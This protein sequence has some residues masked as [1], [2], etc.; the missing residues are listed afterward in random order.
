MRSLIIY[1]SLYGNTEKI[2]KAIGDGISGEVKVL[3]ANGVD[4]A[5]LKGLN[6]LI[7]GS[8]THGGRPSP[9]MQEFLNKI[10]ADGLNGVKIAAFDTRFAYKDHGIGLKILMTVL[11]FAA[12]RIVD[13]LKKKGGNQIIEPDGFFVEGKEGPLKDSELERAKTWAKEISENKKKFSVN[14]SVRAN[15]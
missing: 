13:A 12:G 3:P 11:N 2:A 6:L 1:D 8:P 7:A 9:A 14:L 15:I 10:P 5:E 4:F